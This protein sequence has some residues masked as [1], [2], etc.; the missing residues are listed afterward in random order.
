V[1]V[2]GTKLES[3]H[4]RGQGH[5]VLNHHPTIVYAQWPLR[6]LSNHSRNVSQVQ[7]KYISTSV[8]CTRRAGLLSIANRIP[9]QVLSSILDCWKPQDA[10]GLRTLR[11][12]NIIVWRFV[13]KSAQNGSMFLLLKCPLHLM[14]CESDQ[15]RCLEEGIDRPENVLKRSHLFGLCFARVGTTCRNSSLIRGWRHCK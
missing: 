13:W 4:R 5:W 12:L 10:A 2:L 14:K 3:L 8:L 6:S 15:D 7:L 9:I 11:H 1:R